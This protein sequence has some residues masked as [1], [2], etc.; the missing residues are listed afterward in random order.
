M[1]LIK[2]PSQSFS[3]FV[4][5]S[6]Q[7]N[8]EKPGSALEADREREK[9]SYKLTLHERWRRTDFVESLAE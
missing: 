9:G 4:Q 1:F 3:P 5:T 2:T 6:H 7:Q 8:S